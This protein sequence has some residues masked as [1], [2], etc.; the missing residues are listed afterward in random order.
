MG[1]SLDNDI[2][3]VSTRSMD[4]YRERVA[5]HLRTFPD[6]YDHNGRDNRDVEIM[7]QNLRVVTFAD[8]ELEVEAP[9]TV[10]DKD[11]FLIAGSS[12]NQAGINQNECKME[13]YHAI[14]CIKRGTPRRITVIEPYFS[15]SRSDRTTRRNSV[16]F[17]VHTKILSNLGA[18]TILTYQLHSD[19]SKTAIDPTICH[20]EDIPAVPMMMEYITREIIKSEEYWQQIRSKWVFCSVDAGGEGM[21]RSYAQAFQAPL[22]IAHKQRDYAHTN[23]IKQINILSD[24]DITGRDVWIVDDMIDTGGS[25]VALITELNRRDVASVNIAAIHPVLSGPAVERLK[26]LHHSKMLRELLIL[27]TVNLTQDVLDALPFLRV[28]SSSKQTAEIIM[29]IHENMSLSPFFDDF[30]VQKYFRNPP[31]E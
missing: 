30:S 26:D 29:G 15:P 14:D 1:M 2:L 22:I 20:M 19:K 7:S 5:Y 17:W 4:E 11:V 16:G 18:D 24:T 6:F 27:D 25:I 3:L 31:L 9:F 21:A 28:V 10:R 23:T 12:R 8:G 13:L